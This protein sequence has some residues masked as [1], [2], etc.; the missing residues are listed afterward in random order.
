MNGL[1][2]T[3]YVDKVL[4]ATEH[5]QTNP[6]LTITGE[7]DRVYKAIS[8]DTT[9]ILQQGKPYLDVIRDNLDD[10]V[11]WNPWIE[12]AKAM[13]DFEP[14]SGYKNMVCVEVGAVDGWQK[15]E[16]GETFEGGQILKSYA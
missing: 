1:G 8:Q 16:P 4:D 5:Q 3:T 7:V 9:S 11:V 14:K 13:G 10:T 2:A 15:L 6:S 12:K